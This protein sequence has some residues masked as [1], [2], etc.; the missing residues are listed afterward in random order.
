MVDE[1]SF[2]H[3]NKILQFR[4]KE[5]SESENERDRE[6]LNQN[7]FKLMGEL[8]N[9]GKVIDAVNEL[10]NPEEEFKQLKYLFLNK[11]DIVGLDEK[12]IEIRRLA[13]GGE[14]DHLLHLVHTHISDFCVIKQE[15]KYEEINNEE[16]SEI[17][18]N[19]TVAIRGVVAAKRIFNK[20]NQDIL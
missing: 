14:I 3:P 18:E 12:I 15:G 1:E 10:D 11:L 4:R 2:N 16:L 7:F 17:L 6:M 5:K 13:K 9:I 20:E 19:S 8:E